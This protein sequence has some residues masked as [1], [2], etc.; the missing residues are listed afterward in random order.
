MA[1]IS[2]VNL[3]EQQEHHVLSIRTNINFNDFANIAKESYKKIQDYTERNNLLLAG[4]SYVCYHNS[5]LENLDV[6]L[7]FPVARS[8]D[9]KDDI[10]GH[11]IPVQKGVSGIFLGAYEDTDPLMY[12]IIQ[13]INKHGYELQGDIYNYYLN[14]EDRSPS[15]L[16]TQIVVPIK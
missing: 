16:L 14:D 12:S 8:V 13:W 1:I 15:E 4:G 11:T 10:I 6:E 2:K 7:G 3:I 5:D 9:G